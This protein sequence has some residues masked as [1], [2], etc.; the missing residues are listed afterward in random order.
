MSDYEEV[1]D[2]S[3]DPRALVQEFARGKVEDVRGKILARDSQATG[4]G[5]VVIVGAD[6]VV[7]FEDRVIGKPRSEAQAVAMLSD[8]QGTSHELLTGIA[9]LDVSG[10]RWYEQV[11]ATRVWFAP[12]DQAEIKAYVATGEARGRAGAYSILDRAS[13]LVTRID[14]S[15]S[16]VVGLPMHLLADAL[17]SFGLLPLVSLAGDN[18]TPGELW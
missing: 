11:D 5:P 8:L 7:V 15:P 18:R 10:D 3:E 4:C 14:G 1:F 12:L 17:R 16:N 2:G 6:T 13:L 9:V